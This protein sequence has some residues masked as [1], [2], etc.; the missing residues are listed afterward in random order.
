MAQLQDQIKRL[1]CA[2]TDAPM[3]S[4]KERDGTRYQAPYRGASGG[5]GAVRWE[6]QG[7]S[8]TETYSP[9]GSR[10]SSLRRL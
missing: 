6:Q 2:L 7:A 10:I 1:C 8:G 9:P 3:N 5:R 4:A